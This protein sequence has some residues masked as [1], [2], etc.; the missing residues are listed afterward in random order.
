MVESGNPASGWVIACRLST[1]ARQMTEE[2]GPRHTK[3]AAEK[4]DVESGRIL[5]AQVLGRRRI[6]ETYSIFLVAEE[7]FRALVGDL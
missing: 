1:C 4:K 2:G 3:D 7:G 6:Q 5:R